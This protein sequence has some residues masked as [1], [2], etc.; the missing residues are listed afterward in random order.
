MFIPFSPRFGCLYDVYGQPL[1][2]KLS[3]NSQ[4]SAGAEQ[5][6]LAGRE[7]DKHRIFYDDAYDGLPVSKLGGLCLIVE[8]DHGEK[9]FRGTNNKLSTKYIRTLEKYLKA[10]LGNDR[11]HT[12][13]AMSA[14][15]LCLALVSREV[16][17]L[18]LAGHSGQ[19]V[20]S[21]SGP[22]TLGWWTPFT[23][24]GNCLR[25][26]FVA[27]LGCGGGVRSS[28]EEGLPFAHYMVSDRQRALGFLT[29]VRSFDFES[30]E[31]VFAGVDLA[32][33][34]NNPTP[35]EFILSPGA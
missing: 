10:T 28:G 17:S 6:R 30:P 15:A 32:F 1:P 25:S 11:V 12:I 8:G 18:V 22:D 31:Y 5:L 19:E 21:T 16:T 35:T 23:I 33:M 24:D 34:H 2:V 27:K 9:H 4:S 13:R 3:K 14:E 26:G 29:D 20:Y 7:V